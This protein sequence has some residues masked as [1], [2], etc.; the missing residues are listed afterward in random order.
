[1]RQLGLPG[2]ASLHAA[3]AAGGDQILILTSRGVRVVHLMTWQQRLSTLV[4]LGKLELALL[5][6]VRLHLGAAGADRGLW[7]ADWAPPAEAE[8]VSRQLLTILRALV[9]SKLGSLEADRAAAA[10]AGV[11]NAAEN[12][13]TDVQSVEDA[14]EQ[15]A[16]VAIN[17]CLLL[18]RPD[19]L[20]SDV[21]P[22][23]LSSPLSAA[24]L[25]QLEPRVLGDELPHLAPEVVQALV[26]H[27]SAAGAPHRMER[28]VIKLDVLSLD[29]NQLIPL[30]L[31]YRL[32]GALVH[33]F[34][35]A[36][37][38][39]QTPAAL[40]AVAAAEAAGD[41]GGW[42]T[43]HSDP[44]EALEA[45]AA[46]RL[47]YRLLVYL[48]GCL[49]GGRYPPSTGPA[50]PLEAQAMRM[51]A[52][53]FLLHT[54][55][56]S[57]LETRG[58]WA[59]VAHLDGAGGS[60]STDDGALAAAGLRDPAPAL[61]LMCEMDAEAVLRVL[62]ESLAGW[63]ALEADLV[64]LT[65]EIAPLVAARFGRTV[66][67]AAVDAVVGLLMEGSGG[68][69]TSPAFEPAA[70]R[71]VAEHLAA[72]RAAAE[73]DV[74]LRVL[75][76]LARKDSGGVP[77]AERE[78]IFRDIVAH[79]EAGPARSEALKLAQTAGFHQA[80]AR[81]LHAQGA[82]AAALRCLA[83][84]GDRHPSAPFRYLRDAV[85]DP[86]LNEAEK[87]A[88]RD[89]ALALAPQLVRID[90]TAAAAAVAECLPG[91]AQRAV[92]EALAPW[93]DDQ[94]AFLQAAL[95]GGSS[96]GEMNGERPGSGLSE[97]SIALSSA[98]SRHPLLA[99]LLLQ[100][101]GVSSLYVRLLC[102]FRPAAVLPFLQAADAY[103]VDACLGHCLAA[104]VRPAAAY[105]LERRGD[106]RGALEICLQEVDAA[107]AALVAAGRMSGV[108]RLPEHVAARGT[109]HAAV[110][111]CVRFS[112]DRVDDVVLPGAVGAAAA[113]GNGAAEDPLA[114]VWFEVLQRYVEVIRELQQERREMS[115]IGVGSDPTA[116]ARLSSLEA[117]F[118]AFMEEVI[119]QMA[120]HVPLQSVAAAVMERHGRDGVGDHRA[121]LGSLLGACAFELSIL[122]CASRVTGTDTMQM[123]KRGYQQCM[124]PEA[125]GSGGESGGSGSAGADRQMSRSEAALARLESAQQL[126]QEAWARA[127]AAAGPAASRLLRRAAGEE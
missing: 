8:E 40:L 9:D 118:T 89:E 62:R 66:T 30:C 110:S 121:T 27:F 106:V 111:M 102:R 101:K 105:L 44:K 93:P 119:G 53:T 100:D 127:T 15:L 38:D 12:A 23:F 70:L 72:N 126:G 107:N 67:Q 19:S 34:N 31:K 92:L 28:C 22:R 58:L 17:A 6:A 24:L 49:G 32:Y 86:G 109:L 80:E 61:R 68:G 50:P 36:M 20:F 85:L 25:R 116:A 76:F 124:A 41:A 103:D 35:G 90:A 11:L 83:A 74:L 98:Q 99:P 52:A 14:A 10:A 94:F 81:I 112:Q 4:G 46:L 1:L 65:P 104:G 95:E 59:S 16:D 45:S 91:D 42:N 113:G 96:S 55:A 97:T 114:A 47:G 37:Q 48:R 29:L 57:L 21:A 77:A 39:W 82:H 2:A 43:A 13:G 33:I 7:P 75:R 108:E 73:G 51:H 63:D 122:R 117:A 84:D 3:V 5:C 78:S 87:D 115:T 123:L 18:D 125:V 79:L 64:E 120:G 71:F 54:T 56:A 88:V 60:D 26:E 69:V